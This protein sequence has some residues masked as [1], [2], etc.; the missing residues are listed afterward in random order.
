MA[1][2]AL[3]LVRWF[4]REPRFRGRALNEWV[5]DLGSRDYKVRQEAVEALRAMGPEAVPYL[6]GE[7]TAKGT[8]VERAAE[9]ISKH[10]PEFVKRPLRRIYSP[11]RAVV[12]KQV[13]LNAI[14]A[15][16]TNA[17]A[18]V[19]ALGQVLREPHVGLS[20]LAASALTQQGTNGVPVLIAALDDGDFN[21][22]SAACN[23]LG[24]LR[25]NAAPA[26]PRLARII[27]E[28]R[29][30]IASAAMVAL[31][32]IGEPAVPAMVNLLGDTNSLTRQ[33]G[34][35]ALAQMGIHNNP[36]ARPA[37]LVLTTAASDEDPVVRQYALQALAGADAS[38]TEISG[39]LLVAL[40]DPKAEVRE[41]AAAALALRP[42]VVRENLST[43]YRALED[44]SPTVRA[45]AA[46]AL[47]QIGQHGMGAVPHLERLMTDTNDL[48]RF[49][50][51]DA[52]ETI[53]ASNEYVRAGRN[54]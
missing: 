38:S 36:A 32:R 26:V 14:S 3:L 12:R 33:L 20:S 41:T 51:R 48:V 27:S 37:I 47:G 46:R 42:R 45:T 7:L 43:M 4:D 54:K 25:S 29:G 13:A 17:A 28:E 1:L 53:R 24:L 6:S 16:G 19:P 35:A 50:A 15:M 39:I 49:S 5:D 40:G 9:A 8:P 44:D 31:A 11:G 22:R 21:I 34:A 10:V 2:V 52:I 18:A 30:A 23:S